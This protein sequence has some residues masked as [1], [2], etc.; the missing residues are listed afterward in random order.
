MNKLSCLLV[1]RK[2]RKVG[3]L[4]KHG[5]NPSPKLAPTADILNACKKQEN[6]NWELYERRFLELLQSRHI[7]NMPREI[8]DAGCLLC[9]EPI[10]L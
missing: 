8:L 5:L 3:I 10:S 7:E 1:N 2:L 6:G 9:S 4:G